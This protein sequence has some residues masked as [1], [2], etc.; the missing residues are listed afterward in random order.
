M[1]II[2]W[3]VQWARGMDGRVDP[4]R[5]VRHVRGLADFDLLCLQEVADN[6]PE[7]DGNDATNQFRRFA[8]LLPGYSAIEGIG[9][10][11]RDRE[12]R[13]KRFGNMLFTRYPVEQVIRYVLP[14]EAAATRNMPRVLIEVT[15]VA[16]WGAIRLMTT[17]L[18]YSSDA[19]R[20]AQVEAIREAH[21]TACD[22][23]ATPREDGP[24]TYRRTASSRSAVLTGDFNMRPDDPTKARISSPFPGGAPPLLD[25]WPVRHGSEP[26]PPSFCLYD[27][28]YG[29]AHC[30]DYVFA[31]PDIAERTIAVTY[32]L[33]TQISDHQP[34][35][36]EIED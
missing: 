10:E 3:N 8:E 27:Q 20:E 24:H 6:F 5:V 22:R 13:P 34:V 21:R 11:T 28:T 35:L 19:L 7:L 36:V 30:C 29:E 15:A 12:G 18:E 4:A 25:L 17:H 2:T 31:T 26:H 9:L 1:R 16:P 32:D 14:W 33:T 23:D